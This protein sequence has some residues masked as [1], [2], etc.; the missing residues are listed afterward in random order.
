M[1]RNNEP[2]QPVAMTTLLTTDLI[3]VSRGRSFPSDELDSYTSAGCGWSRPTA[4]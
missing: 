3:G 4:R 2:L 1:S